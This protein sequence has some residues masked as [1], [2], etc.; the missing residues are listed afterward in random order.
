[1]GLRFRKTFKTGP[2]RWNTS[3][4]GMG[5]SWGFPGFRMGVSADGRR[6]VSISIPGTGLS[7]QHYFGQKRQ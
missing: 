1:M 4:R 3:N 5:M 7:Y 2:I 6:Y